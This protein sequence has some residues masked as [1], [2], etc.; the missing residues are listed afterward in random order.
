[1]GKIY[2]SCSPS[3]SFILM[4]TA[5]IVA[6]VEESEMKG[7]QVAVYSLHLTMKK[8]FMTLHGKIILKCMCAFS[9]FKHV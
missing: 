8:L 2:C 6:A 1:M 7:G 5:L 3:P 4:F 9:Y